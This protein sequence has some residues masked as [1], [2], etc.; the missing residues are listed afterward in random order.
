MTEAFLLPFLGTPL[1]GIPIVQA[2]M[3]GGPST[4]TLAAAVSNAGGFGFLAAG[5]QTAERLDADI[6]AAASLTSRPF[7]VNLFVP[8][9][10][11]A[12]QDSLLSYAELLAS[13]ANPRGVRLGIPH[14]DDDD[15]DRKLEVVLLRRPGLVSFTFGVPS[16]AT[17]DRFRAVTIPTAVTVTSPAEAVLAEAAGADLLVVQGPEAGGHR[18]T[19]DPAKPPATVPLLELIGAVRGQSSL[20]IIASGGL[21]SS[22]DMRAVRAAGAVAAQVGTAFLLADEAGTSAT[23]RAA[24]T[25]AEFTETG[26]THAFSGRAARGL[27]NDFMRRFDGVAPL[28][29]PEVHQITSP[30]RKAA[31]AA[32][33]PHSTNLW[34]G[35]GFASA[36]AGSA[37]SILARLDP[38]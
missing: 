36:H 19:F 5:Y 13:T 1:T 23:H 15:W 17:L 37:A 20:P 30:L 18:G 34:A 4:P 14:D 33:D 11:V 31:A 6:V 35:V 29:Y 25:S 8:R 22:A 32:G 28:G 27:I 3:A 26:V 16:E 12:D 24:L 7:G 38:R 2:P 21:G 10:S 9:E